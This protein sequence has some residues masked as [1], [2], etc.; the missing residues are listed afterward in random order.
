MTVY[1]LMYGGLGNRLHSLAGAV[2][3]AEVLNKKLVVC[4]PVTHE[5]GIAFRELFDT[6]IDEIQAQDI[7]PTYGFVQYGIIPKSSKDYPMFSN[8][9][10]I[11]SSGLTQTREFIERLKHVDIYFAEY[12]VRPYTSIGLFCKQ[13]RF[14][15]EF[16]KVADD[17]V[18]RHNVIASIHVRGTDYPTD[19]E[20][21][22]RMK[23]NDIQAI[24]MKRGKVHG[25]LFVCSDE[26]KYEDEL[27]AYYHHSVSRQDK[28]YPTKIDD[29]KPFFIEVDH[30]NVHRNK[31]HMTGAIIDM[32]IM[33]QAASI[34][35]TK[36]SS[37]A[38]FAHLLFIRKNPSALHAM[39]NHA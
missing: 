30:Y 26:K 18:Q 28:V 12:C 33:S 5:C 20:D 15:D 6:D 34:E 22:K 21:M 11:L 39:Y 7:C 23:S 24:I 25:S 27:L 4:W 3:F 37:L 14:K 8:V 32:L 29:T 2:Q 17:F 31:D 1:A 13:F 9:L 38:Y 35:G 36:Y 10:P 19:D 16:Q